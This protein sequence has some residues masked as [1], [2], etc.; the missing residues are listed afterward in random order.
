MTYKLN[1]VTIYSPESGAWRARKILGTSGEGRPL[2]TGPYSFEIKYSFLDIS[3]FDKIRD[4]WAA[5]S[6]T[7]TL[8]AELPDVL[9]NTYQFREFSGCYM[10]EP[11]VS[12]YFEQYV[13]QVL[14]VITNINA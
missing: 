7:G 12:Q 2:L 5:C 3:E 13:T 14:V 8:V 6:A 4:V 10:Q 11:T 1:G 9:A